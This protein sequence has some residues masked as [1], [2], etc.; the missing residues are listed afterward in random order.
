MSI[1]KWLLR[2]PVVSTLCSVFNSYAFR[3]DD[4]AVGRF[5][6]F[7][8]IVKALYV[9]V[10]IACLFTTI[11]LHEWAWLLMK[12]C[13]LSIEA[14]GH[15]AQAPG[16]LIVDVVPGLLGF[17]IGVYALTFI[18]PAKIV[19]E[20]DEALTFAVEAGKK[21]YGSVFVLNVDMAFPLVIMILALCV[22]TI[23]QVFF[24]NVSL[25]ILAWVMFWL[26]MV[27]LLEIVGVLFQLGD[28]A[29]L[30]KLK[31]HDPEGNGDIK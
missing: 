12:K 29:I 24:E 26:S 25:L 30:D 21:K 6:W 2:I 22:G 27:A 5:S 7:V 15:F 13:S 4:S 11:I 16:A 3:G 1:Y 18:L 23:Q 17:G 28:H 9:Q 10:T 19:R 31:P 20:V 8:A 14:L